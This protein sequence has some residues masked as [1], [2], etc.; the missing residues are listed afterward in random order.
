MKSVCGV[1]KCV[2]IVL[3]DKNTTN[4]IGKEAPNPAFSQPSL[5]ITRS[6]SHWYGSG[7]SEWCISRNIETL[8]PFWNEKFQL[9]IQ[10]SSTESQLLNQNVYILSFKSPYWFSIQILY[11]KYINSLCCNCRHIMFRSFACIITVL[12]WTVNQPVLTVCSFLL[13]I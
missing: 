13:Y 7:V 9:K 12:L 10:N 1:E 2:R 6:V 4:Y 3:P 5:C 11:C 8:R